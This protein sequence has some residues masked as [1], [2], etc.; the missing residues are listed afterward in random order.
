[1]LPVR[2]GH[3]LA[4]NSNSDKNNVVIASHNNRKSHSKSKSK[5]NKAS[6]DVRA[7][8]ALQ[9]ASSS[10]PWAVAGE[11]FFEH[12]PGDV[13]SHKVPRC[14]MIPFVRCQLRCETV[15]AKAR[16]LGRRALGP[17]LNKLLS[18]PA[19][20]HLMTNTCCLESTLLEST[21]ILRQNPNP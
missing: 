7:M 5:G 8:Q 4:N 18:P 19:P 2:R 12:G 11:V 20:Q 1:M 10:N 13:E 17:S 15:P 14:S 3:G 9:A 21:L 6:K 16:C